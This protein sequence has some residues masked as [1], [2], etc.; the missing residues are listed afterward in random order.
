MCRL[1][2]APALKA[3]STRDNSNHGSP[4]QG[5]EGLPNGISMYVPS[6]WHSPVPPQR[7]KDL[8]LTPA[9]TPKLAPRFSIRQLAST[10]PY[11]A[12]A[13]EATPSTPDAPPSPATS[14]RSLIRAGVILTRA[15]LLT[16][17]ETP[18]ESAYYFYQKRLNERLT[19]PF[20]Q[21]AF[22]KRDTP[23]QLDWAEKLRERGGVVAREIG[24]YNGRSA[25]AWDD[26]LRVGDGLSGQEA[27]RDSILKDAE[28][29]VSE[30]AEVIPLE[31]RVPVERP[32]DRVTEADRTGDVKRLDRELARTLYLVV[33]KEDGKWEFPTASVSTDEAL[34]DVRTQSLSTSFYR[35]S[36]S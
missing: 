4:K 35:E 9:A 1:P 2:N 17:S 20:T 10:R 32:L 13:A 24:Q 22:F 3:Q 27:L 12:A 30:D 21:A 7:T 25:S 18:L 23:P 33:Q 26:E 19:L 11:T 34:H 15:P 6:N 36:I 28:A 5:P 29:R 31:D 16:R 14:P 8:T